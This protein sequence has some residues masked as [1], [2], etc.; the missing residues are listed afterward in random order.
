MPISQVA[1]MTGTAMIQARVYSRRPTRA[2]SRKPAIG[3]T[4]RSVT[5]SWS[6]V[7]RAALLAHARVL[8]DQWRA[9]VAV[10]GDH[11]GQADGGLGRRDGHHQQRDQRR[12]RLQ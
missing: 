8:V 2:V 7:M 4:S 11:D 3:S 5:A 9:P 12:V 1:T 10:D 6:V